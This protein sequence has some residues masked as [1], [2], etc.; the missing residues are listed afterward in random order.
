MGLLSNHSKNFLKI[1]KIDPSQTIN[2]WGEIQTS[3]WNDK[4]IFQRSEG[5]E[6]F[7]FLF[8][9]GAAQS[10]VCSVKSVLAHVCVCACARVQVFHKQLNKCFIVPD[11]SYS[12]YLYLTLK[13]LLPREANF[14]TNKSKSYFINKLMAL[15]SIRIWC[16]H[17]IATIKGY[18][19]I[20]FIFA[21]KL[22]NKRHLKYL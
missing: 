20:P 9:I 15:I 14:K 17:C 6:H 3:Y 1:Y 4:K 10:S 8:G 13:S 12:F 11:I 19:L 22:A 16:L 18:F 7:N 5:N 21:N 2:K